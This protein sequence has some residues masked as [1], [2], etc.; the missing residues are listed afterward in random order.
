MNVPPLSGRKDE[1]VDAGRSNPKRA[2]ASAYAWRGPV[3]PQAAAGRSSVV[4]RPLHRPLSFASSLEHS[5][6]NALTSHQPSPAT[7]SLRNCVH[8]VIHAIAAEGGE[9][10]AR[11]NRVLPKRTYASRVTGSQRQLREMMMSAGQAAQ[12]GRRPDTAGQPAS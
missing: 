8:P 10:F 7:L 6:H 5:T 11:S 4:V 3:L 9:R 1:T 12:G 2:R